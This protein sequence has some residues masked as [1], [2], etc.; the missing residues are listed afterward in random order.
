MLERGISR[1]PIPWMAKMCRCRSQ[2]PSLFPCPSVVPS[3]LHLSPALYHVTQLLSIPSTRR[4]RQRLRSLTSLPSPPSLSHMSL[5]A[6]PSQPSR[7]PVFSLTSIA[8]DDH[9]S[10]TVSFSS[11]SYIF[12][13]SKWICGC[14]NRRD[15][16]DGGPQDPSIS[17]FGCLGHEAGARNGSLA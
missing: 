3:P 5:G 14:H 10:M 2:Q 8:V 7:Q 9:D 4:P 6:L 12:C 1:R 13:S 17:S 15:H 16:R 11:S